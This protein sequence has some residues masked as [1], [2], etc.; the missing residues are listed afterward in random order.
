MDSMTIPLAGI[1]HLT[2]M[3]TWS[4]FRAVEPSWFARLCYCSPWPNLFSTYIPH[5]FRFDFRI[6]QLLHPEKLVRF[7][8]PVKSLCMRPKTVLHLHVC[9]MYTPL[10]WHQWDHKVHMGTNS[11]FGLVLSE[12]I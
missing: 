12:T 9:H 4:N 11:A 6:K 5:N 1:H 3:K 7:C 2:K 8:C 10:G